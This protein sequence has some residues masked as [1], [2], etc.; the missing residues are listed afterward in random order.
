MP[1]KVITSKRDIEA[2][3]SGLSIKISETKP[4]RIRK[5]LEAGDP[6]E[7][8]RVMRYLADATLLGGALGQMIEEDEVADYRLRRN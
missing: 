3:L 6:D 2:A 5:N 4:D 7:I 8:K 1:I